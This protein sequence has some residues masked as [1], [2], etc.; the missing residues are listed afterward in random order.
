M[1][2]TEQS[3]LKD[4]MG[5]IQSLKSALPEGEI[6][7]LTDQIIGEHVSGLASKVKGDST[8]QGLQ[9]ITDQLNQ[10][11]KDFALE[12]VVTE[13]NA[14]IDDVS[15][16]KDEM[17]AT[18]Q[19]NATEGEAKFSGIQKMI[20][21]GLAKTSSDSQSF[22]EKNL[23]PV[24][25]AIEKLNEELFNANKDSEGKNVSLQVTITEIQ[26]QLEKIGNK[27][28]NSNQKHTEGITSTRADLEKNIAD[29]I[30]SLR[31]EL[32]TRMGNLVGSGNMNRNI[33]VGGN[34][35]VLSRYT[36]LNIKPG[37]NITLS[38]TNNDTTKAVD[39]TITS[40][41]GAGT[42]R[43]IA[44]V[45]STQTAGAIAATDYVYIASAGIQLTMPTASGNTNLYTIKNTAASS[46][47]L[48]PN[49]VETIDSQTN[50]ILRTQYTSV[51][52]ISDG[53]SNWNIT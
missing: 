41:G 13:L 44:P 12:P 14:L 49:G 52:L 24:M 32:M 29:S 18:F 50:L 15:A 39:L 23:G 34:T 51:D 25:D 1:N 9:A 5:R 33:A 22:T 11:K 16:L 46:V 53:T 36:D 7:S 48:T 8:I 42:S 43:I 19:K 21:D 20:A 10:F 45:S 40:S 26:S 6:K 30:I 28:K 37:S 2:P 4:L 3:K 17:S 31:K 27:I 47:L 38:Y 35:S